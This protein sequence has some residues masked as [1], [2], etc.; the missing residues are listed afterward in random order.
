MNNTVMKR[1]AALLLWGFVVLGSLGAQEARIVEYAQRLAKTFAQ[2]GVAIQTGIGD[3]GVQNLAVLAKGGYFPLTMR[4]KAGVPTVLRVYTNK[5]YDCGRAFY[6]PE[7]KK[8]ATLPVKGATAF[9][10]GPQKAGTSVFGTCGMGM[11]TFEI[12][13][14]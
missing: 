3:D 13:F 14:E 4:A 11:Y 9:V 10:L 2:D 7:L 5:T 8:Q 6:L 12:R 1:A